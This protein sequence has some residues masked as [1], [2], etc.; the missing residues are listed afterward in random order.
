MQPLDRKLQRRVWAR[1]YPQQPAGLTLR[2]RESLSRCLMRSK[3]NLAIYEK[4]QK[5]T[6]Y[7]PA[8]AK[9]Y[10]ETAEHIKMLQQM[11]L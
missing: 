9:L 6:I 7:G 4:M 3:E 1:V 2:Q 10:T 5:H 8:F 11:L